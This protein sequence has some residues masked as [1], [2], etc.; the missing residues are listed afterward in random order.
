V[1][2]ERDERTDD[3]GGMK[4]KDVYR[5]PVTSALSLTETEPKGALLL[6]STVSSPRFVYTLPFFHPLRRLGKMMW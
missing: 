3:N 1:D 4:K 2:S 5:F 6:N